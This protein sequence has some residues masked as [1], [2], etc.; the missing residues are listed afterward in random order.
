[1]L[2]L[3]HFVQ[4][5]CASMSDCDVDLTQG[6]PCPSVPSWEQRSFSVR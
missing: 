1:M 5:E 6:L 2:K 4:G 3:K